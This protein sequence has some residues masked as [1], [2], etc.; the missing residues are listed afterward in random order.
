MLVPVL[1]LVLLLLVL[2]VLLLVLLMLLRALDGY[3]RSRSWW[4]ECVLVG[5]VYLL[6]YY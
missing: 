1:L 6:V 3:C 4:R 5:C 2:P